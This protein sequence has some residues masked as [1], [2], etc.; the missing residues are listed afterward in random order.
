MYRLLFFYFL[1]LFSFSVKSQKYKPID[2]GSKIHFVIKNFG[3][4]TGGDFTGLKGEVTFVP[5]NITSSAFNVSISV[6]T[7]DTDN[8]T[9]D[10]HLRS[11]E[12][13]DAD[14]YPEITIVS[15]R[16]TQTNK[17]KSGWY[18]FTGNLSLHGIT[19]PVSFPFTA[20][21]K[22]DDY[23]LTS[24]FDINRLDFGVGSRSAVLSNTVKISLS[25][26]AKKS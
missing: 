3:I 7:V 10:E 25:V 14:K 11:K 5:A 22:G 8:D 16:I 6:K 1:L 20:V 4:N 19:K 2:A 13:F 9:R 15:S 12:Y 21:K 17:T 26:L 23:L 24:S 18:Y